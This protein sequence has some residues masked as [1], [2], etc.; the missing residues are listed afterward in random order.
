MWSG[1]A[2]LGSTITA[3]TFLRARV[4]HHYAPLILRTG[5]PQFSQSRAEQLYRDAVLTLMDNDAERFGGEQAARDILKQLNTLLDGSHTIGRVQAQVRAAQGNKPLSILEAE[6][7]E[8]RHRAETATDTLAGETLRQ[9]ADI[10][11]ARLESIRSLSGLI[12]RMDAQQEVVCQTLASVQTSLARRS[13]VGIPS[14]TLSTSDQV[15]EVS[16][17]VAHIN[18]QTRAVEQAVQEVLS[19]RSGG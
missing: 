10:A 2:I 12:E 5:L 19:L 17:T 15:R 16:E 7:H 3:S 11:A 6:V 14:N 13:A 4:H 18:D 1:I 9:S 8:L